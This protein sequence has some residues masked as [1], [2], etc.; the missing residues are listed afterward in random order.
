[1]PDACETFRHASLHI[2]SIED[3]AQSFPL[4][5]QTVDS[6]YLPILGYTAAVDF[7]QQPVQTGSAEHFMLKFP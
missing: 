1:M 2:V 4:S 7:I 3:R 6:L 5:K